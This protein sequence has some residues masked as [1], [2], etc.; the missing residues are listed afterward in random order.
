MAPVALTPLAPIANKETLIQRFGDWITKVLPGIFGKGEK[1]LEN[2]YDVL[3]EEE[4]KA[5]VWSS[6]AIA[7]VNANLDAIPADVIAIL[8]QKFPDL[9]LDNLHGFLDD[10]RNKVDNLQSEIPLTL[11]D[12]IAWA[13]A[14]LGQHKGDHSTWAVISTT[15]VN[16]LA[17]FFSPAT[18]IEKFIA[19]GLFIY[20]AIVKPHVEDG[21]AAPVSQGTVPGAPPTDPSLPPAL[22]PP[23]TDETPA[24]V[25]TGTTD[26]AQT[27]DK[28]PP[29]DLPPS[30][31]NTPEEDAAAL[32]GDTEPEGISVPADPAPSDETAAPVVDD[33]APETAIPVDQPVDDAAVNPGV[34]A[35]PAHDPIEADLLANRAPTDFELNNGGATAVPVPEPAVDQPAQDAPAPE[36]EASNTSTNPADHEEAA[37]E[38]VIQ[39]T[40]LKPGS[41]EFETA[42]EA[43]VERRLAAL[44]NNPPA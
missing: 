38:T 23:A 12:A 16:L 32:A 44:K 30:D 19:A 28:N 25:A 17:T 18:A 8:K 26:T 14:Y 2:A 22:P 42:V 9:P 39:D 13:Q 5:G 41:P 11:E 21:T 7:V 15:A 3:L 37:V 24:P 33:T 35:D 6:G 1:T 36:T 20:H 4:K 31:D 40:D 29:A 27:P 10:L 43:E 34:P